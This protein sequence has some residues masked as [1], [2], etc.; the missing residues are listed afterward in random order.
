MTGRP[1]TTRRSELRSFRRPLALG[2]LASVAVHAAAFAVARR[3]AVLLPPSPARSTAQA[4]REPLDAVVPSRDVLRAVRVAETREIEI[5]PPPEDVSAEPAEVREPGE[6]AG[7]A[8]AASGLE[9]RGFRRP[10][11]GTGGSARGAPVSPPVPRSVLPE[12][13]PPDEVRGLTVTVRVRVDSAGR[14]VGP[15]E[16]R[17]ETPSESFDV[18]LVKKVL[19]MRFAP[20]RT[21]AGRPVEGWAELTFSF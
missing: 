11:H 3:A 4:S 13:D 14:P 9:A 1:D 7:A 19:E 17:P 10:S 18:R 8:L 21:A 5:P 15:V 20:A 16:L 12:W 6:A 2:L